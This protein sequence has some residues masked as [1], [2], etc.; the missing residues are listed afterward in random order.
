MLAFLC[1]IA[2]AFDHQHSGLQAVLDRRVSAGRVDYAGLKADPAELDRYLEAA[3]AVSLVG[4]NAAQKKAFY[5]NVYNALTLDLVADHYPLRSILDLDGGKVWDTRRFLV[6]GSRITLNDLENR[7]LRSLGDPRIHA[8]LN[9]ASL[10]CPPL[11]AKVFV[12]DTLD[13][14]LDAA[15]SVWVAGTTVS[16]RTIRISKIFDWFGEDFVAGYGSQYQDLAGLEGKQEAA[17]NFVSRYAPD[18]SAVIKAGNLTIQY[19][20]YDWSLNVR[21]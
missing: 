17:L 4:V 15:A 16:G 14:Q 13:L 8:A 1:S 10:G 21:R 3:G 2:L 7:L 19:E 9:C 6:A 5:L 11:A 12:A 18:K 20:D